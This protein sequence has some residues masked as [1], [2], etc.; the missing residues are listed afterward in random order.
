MLSIS[1]L[2]HMI[3]AG[4]LAG[5]LIAGL[6]C[7][8]IGERFAHS[9]TILGVGV[10]W[11]AALFLGK[12]FL[13]EGHAPYQ[14][15]LYQWLQSGGLHLHVGVWVDT[16]SVAMINVVTFVSFFVHI[17]S[18]GYMKGDAGYARFFSYVSLFTFA[19]LM[20]VLA[21]NFMQLFFG[22]EGVGVVSYLLIGF[23]FNR[24]SAAAG[25]QKAF[26][27]NRVGDFGFLMGIA[28]VL[29][30]MGSLDFTHVLQGSALLSNKM[31]AAGSLRVIDVLCLCLFV[32]AMGKSAQIPLHVW[33]PE[34]MEGPTPISAL[35]HAATM[36]TAGVYMIIRLS[37]LFEHSPL[38]LNVIMVLGAS[39]ALFLGAVALVQFDIKRVVAYSTLSQL[40]YMMAA[41]GASA[42]VPALF[43]LL[44]H[45][46]F[47]ALLFLGAGSVIV[48][49]HHEQDMRQMG[50]L[51][52]KMPITFITGLIGSL[53]LV[54]LPPFAGFYSKE[55]IITAVGLSKL[56]GASYASFCLILGAGVT[57]LYTFRAFWL[58]FFGKY[59]GT[60]YPLN[61][62]KESPWSITLP[63]IVLAVPSA[64]LGWAM[65]D[66][67]FSTQGVW[68]S[69]GAHSASAMHV[70]THLQHEYASSFI[71]LMKDSVCH[72]PFWLTVLGILLS[73]IFCLKQ[74]P[75][76]E[77]LLA[78]FKPVHCILVAKFGFDAFNEKVIGR[79]YQ[80]TAHALF[81]I[82]DQTFLDRGMVLGCARLVGMVARYAR[83]LQTGYLYHYAWVML[84]GLVVLLV[85]NASDLW[86]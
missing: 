55:A 32:G 34:S 4:P 14:A 72:L 48:A 82:M 80:G 57:A 70:L 74:A 62:V 2:V 64:L 30:H 19:M 44:T 84:L 63:L 43:H 31:M 59:Q 28:L 10:A 75:W 5:A 65:I 27:V 49:L 18:M 36:V 40:G 12:L 16:L 45:A 50:G 6:G 3:L 13:L 52:H 39:G 11:L 25:A 23:W 8:F 81:S 77:H 66:G 9:I 37:P 73:Y 15:T 67:I 20:L 56:P 26:V 79:V 29:V 38:A 22:W 7:R 61:K 86:Q 78:F 42:Y 24:P 69:V 58:T 85:I 76:Q 68:G 71:D 54:A 60:H 47:K 33:L 1:T 41:V 51:R 21:D 17:Y 46:C 35:I 53:A 83:G